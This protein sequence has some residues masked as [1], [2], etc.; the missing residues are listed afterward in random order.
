MFNILLVILTAGMLLGLEISYF[1][2]KKRPQRKFVFLS[3]VFL[4]LLM[5]LVFLISNPNM[6]TFFVHLAFFTAILTS[7]IGDLFMDK[8]LSVTG[9]RLIDGIVAFSVAHAFY[10]IGFTLWFL[11]TKQLSIS[12]QGIIV[13]IILGISLLAYRFTG[14]HFEK[15][16]LRIA[17]L[18]YSLIITTT[19]V[20]AVIVGIANRT[21]GRA[22]AMIGALLFYL[23]DLTLAHRETKPSKIN[24]DPFIHFS[25]VL[26]QFFL[27]TAIML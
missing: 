2:V 25:Y 10:I 13:I 1:K 9:N 15:R 26:G 12:Q 6:P 5:S 20:A 7:F 22:L 27:Q 24:L 21:L 18:T 11:Q 3:Q 4:I 8:K 16:E 17:G 19:L 23:S 14:Y